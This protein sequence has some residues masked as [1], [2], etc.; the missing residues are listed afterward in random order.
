ME[1]PIATVAVNGGLE[2]DLPTDMTA[3]AE[4]AEAVQEAVPIVVEEPVK[5][6]IYIVR[7][8]RPEQTKEEEVIAKL[9][10]D[11]KAHIVK[12][13]AVVAKRQAVRV[14]GV[15]AGSRAGVVRCAGVCWAGHVIGVGQSAA[16][17][18]TKCV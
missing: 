2:N 10:A 5:R 16:A 11:V 3:E 17:A 9:Q 7:L 15:Q 12:I 18:R 13:K 4:P 1:D 14:G 6:V 8:P